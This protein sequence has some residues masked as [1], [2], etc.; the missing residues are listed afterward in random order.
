MLSSGLAVG[1]RFIWATCSR[2]ALPLKRTTRLQRLLCDFSQWQVNLVCLQRLFLSTTV[3]QVCA[4]GLP[5]APLKLLSQL[6][7]LSQL[8][9]KWRCCAAG[10]R[11]TCSRAYVF[12]FNTGHLLLCCASCDAQFSCVTSDVALLCLTDSPER[13]LR[14]LCWR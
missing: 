9:I 5:R 2:D 4:V 7:A 8:A 3:A 12:L 6:R 13:E 14:V 11:R 1:V 10:S